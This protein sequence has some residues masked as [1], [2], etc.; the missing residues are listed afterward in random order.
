MAAIWIRVCA[1]ILRFQHTATRRWLLRCRRCACAC[2]TCFNTQPP[3]GGCGGV[4][5]LHSRL[6]CFNTQPPEGG[7]FSAPEILPPLPVSTHSHPKVA[8]GRGGRGIASRL[9]STHSHPKVAAA[10][11]WVCEMIKQVSTHSHP[12]VAAGR[13]VGIGH[14]PAVS[15]HSH[16]KVAA[17]QQAVHDIARRTVSTHSHPKVAAKATEIEAGGRLFQHTATRRWLPQ[18]PALGCVPCGF[19]TQPPEGGCDIGHGGQRGCGVS[20]HS[21]PKV[22]ASAK[23]PNISDV[24]WFQ[25]TATRR[26]LLVP[27]PPYALKTM[28]QHTATRRW[29]PSNSG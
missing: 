27:V 2:R 29:L 6:S 5:P 1:W 13:G 23:S 15:T 18:A 12:K 24:A 21:H 26:W 3:E 8:A 28:F 17:A 19:N 16:P 9:V 20:T 22:A 7:C 25:H 4:H 11:F 10:L 14:A